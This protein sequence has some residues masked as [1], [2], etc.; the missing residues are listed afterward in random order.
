MSDVGVVPAVESICNDVAAQILAL[1]K[2]IERRGML[3]RQLFK[4]I[5]ATFARCRYC[6]ASIAWVTHEN[7]VKAPYDF[8]GLNHHATCKKFPGRRKEVRNG[9]G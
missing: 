6:D 3:L 8:D 4:C 1:N 2:E 7:G 5:G 9:N